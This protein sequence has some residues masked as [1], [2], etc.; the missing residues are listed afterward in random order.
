MPIQWSTKYATGVKEVDNQHQ[1]LFALINKL[2]E[3]SQAAPGKEVI[4]KALAF[5]ETYMKSHF[6]LWHR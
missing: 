3:A 4:E 5:L 6:L 1:Q 2:S